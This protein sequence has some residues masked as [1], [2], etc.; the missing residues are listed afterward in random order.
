MENPATWGPAERTIKRALD[1]YEDG[2]AQGV[3]GLSPY[4]MIAREL[5]AAGLLVEH[6]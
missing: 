2:R 6:D 3:I 5:R 1:R 4:A